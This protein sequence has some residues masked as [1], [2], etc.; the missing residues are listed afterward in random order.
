MRS[1]EVFYLQRQSLAGALTGLQGAVDL[2]GTVAASKVS[3][4]GHVPVEPGDELQGA[5]AGPPVAHQVAGDGEEADDVDAGLLHLG[6]CHVA[7][8]GRGGARGLVV[9]PDAV[10]F[11][12][13][14]S[15]EECG[16]F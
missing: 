9:G 11:G 10:A 8:Q 15:G 7:D 12:S 1:D 4:K 16:A 6:V 3:V 5:G 2:G 14:R 13:E